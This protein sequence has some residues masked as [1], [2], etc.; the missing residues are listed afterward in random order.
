[1]NPSGQK[2]H[3][4]Y[5]HHDDESRDVQGGLSWRLLVRDIAGSC[6]VNRCSEGS[7]EG[8]RN[9]EVVSMREM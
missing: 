8:V 7:N 9:G 4:N 6:R 1:M 3:Y 5:Y 2:K